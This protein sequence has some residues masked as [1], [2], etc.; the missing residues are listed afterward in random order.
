MN[1]Y[2]MLAVVSAVTLLST[3]LLAE[4]KHDHMEGHSHDNGGHSM[5]SPHDMGSMGTP[6]TL[7]PEQIEAMRAAMPK[8]FPKVP[9]GPILTGKVIEVIDGG[10][11]SY[12]ELESD[13]K[14]V[15]IAGIQVE[16]KVG[17]IVSY[18]ENVTMENFTSR[19]LN[20]TFDKI[21]FAS[22]VSVLP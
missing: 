21:I 4:D 19:A 13:N 14:K 1:K 5:G 6:H 20:K 8:D 16:A 7:T 15:W 11:Y 10:G 3:P 18:I 22:S 9:D 17:D 2:C 12:I